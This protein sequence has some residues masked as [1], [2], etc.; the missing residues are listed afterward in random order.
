MAAS[1]ARGADHSGL[2]AGDDLCLSHLVHAAA[3]D[4]R[5][6]I[7]LESQ[8]GA[9][10]IAVSLSATMVTARPRKESGHD[11][12]DCD[13]SRASVFVLPAGP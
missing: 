6:G 3:G 12:D 5:V 8:D 2:S 11:Q 7:E 9:N 13:V 10:S 1:S 4:D